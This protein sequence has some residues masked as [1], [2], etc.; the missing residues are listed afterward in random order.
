MR[1]FLVAFLFAQMASAYEVAFL[2][3]RDARGKLVQ[4]EKNGQFAHVAI[5]ARGLWLHAHPYRGVELVSQDVL[6]RT[7]TLK[8]IVT[9][10]GPA[11]PGD[12]VIRQ[13]LGKPYDH[14]YTWGDDKIYCSELVAKILHLQPEKMKF[15]GEVWKN[16]IHRPQNQ[17]GLSPDDLFS[18]FRR[19]GDPIHR[20]VN[21]CSKF[22]N[23]DEN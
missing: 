18:F 1:L 8:L 23:A 5:R 20:Q 7:G 16:Q 13:F 22:L 11:E 3:V 2:E 9:T 4:L 21:A 6:E 15:A 14:D 12:E 19:R 10:P 17:L